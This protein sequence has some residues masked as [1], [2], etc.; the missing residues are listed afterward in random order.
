MFLSKLILD[1]IAINVKLTAQNVGDY[2]Y[3]DIRVILGVVT[4]PMSKIKK[5]LEGFDKGKPINRL[6]FEDSI[7]KLHL[8][9][10]Y[11]LHESI[12][13]FQPNRQKPK[14]FIITNIDQSLL[15]EL[16]AHVEN[17]GTNRQSA[18][19]HGK[20]HSFRVDGSMLTCRKMNSHPFVVLFD[21]R[22]GF[23]SP[24][25][26]GDNILIVENLQLFLHELSTLSFLVRHCQF[27]TKYLQNLDIV[28]G[29][30]NCITNSLHHRF[31][32]QY[33]NVFCLFDIDLGGITIAKNLLN[34]GIS[35]PISFLYPSKIEERLAL[36]PKI[37]DNKTVQEVLKLCAGEP[38]LK[39]IANIIKQNQKFIEQ[40]DYL[41]WTL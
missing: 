36:V 26:L 31:L 29:D 21:N 15:A 27:D 23:T 3:T 13:Y 33:H 17:I 24:Q 7:K 18:S 22:Q 14:Q 16:R 40:E 12:D 28:W 39:N 9:H 8:K 20:S 11:N 41:Q 32:E 19:L 25:K 5:C 37:Q 35:K 10:N 6:V 2:L 4:M 1:I 38:A 30:G 34:S